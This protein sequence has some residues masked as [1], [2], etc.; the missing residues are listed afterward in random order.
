MTN[1]TITKPTVIH[2]T[3]QLE[4]KLKASPERVFTAFADETTKRRWFY[5]ASRGAIVARADALRDHERDHRH[6]DRIH[7]ERADRRDRR[8]HL[9]GSEPHPRL[10]PPCRGTAR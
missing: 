4:R 6:P 9:Q 5:D 3:F 10:D 2:S 1:S 8:P 7:P